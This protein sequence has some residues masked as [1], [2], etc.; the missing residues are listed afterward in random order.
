M[1]P[2]HV[3]GYLNN[4]A[5]T[6][7]VSDS[8]FLT[9]CVVHPGFVSEGIECVPGEVYAI[10]Y[11]ETEGDP[12][13]INFESR[14]SSVN[15]KTHFTIQPTQHVEQCPAGAIYGFTPEILTNPSTFHEQLGFFIRVAKE[16]IGMFSRRFT[17]LHNGEYIRLPRSVYGDKLEELKSIFSELEHKYS[18]RISYELKKFRPTIYSKHTAVV[19]HELKFISW[20]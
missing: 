15:N 10:F 3:K 5:S 12:R 13:Y 4:S 18:V 8:P 11:T 16:N 9:F 2:C 1:Y 17:A 20:D 19:D 7:H 14:I 6:Q